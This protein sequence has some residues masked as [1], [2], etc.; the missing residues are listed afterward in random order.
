M[1]KIKIKQ[2]GVYWIWKILHEVLAE[3]SFY[4]LYV[5]PESIYEIIIWYLVHDSHGT[6]W[7]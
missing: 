6:Q 4:N 3:M 1:S 5:T 2:A 7:P